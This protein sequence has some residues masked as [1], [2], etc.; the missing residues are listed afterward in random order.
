[1]SGHSLIEAFNNFVLGDP[2]VASLGREAVR[3]SPDFERAF[4]LGYCLIHG[5]KEWPLAFERWTTKTTVHPDPAKRSKYD[6]RRD[7]DPL[8]AVIAAEARVHRYRALVSLLRRGE[9][10]GRGLPAAAG[11]PETILRPVWSQEQFHFDPTTGDIL[12]DNA[13]SKD[14]YDRYI[15]RWLGVVLERR[16]T[17]TNPLG[18]ASVGSRTLRRRR[19]LHPLESDPKF[20]HEKPFTIAEV[21]ALGSLAEA[22]ARLVFRHPDVRVLCDRAIAVAEAQ[23]IPFEEDGGL[24]AEFSGHDERLLPLR[25]FPKEADDFEVYEPPS[26]EEDAIFA[27]YFHDGWPPDIKAYYDA[28][29]VRARALIEMLQEQRVLARGHAADGHLIPIA[30]TI[31]RHEDYYIHPPTGDVY[32]AAPHAMKKKWTGVILETADRP[33]E[34][35]MFHVKP[36]V[37]HVL[38]SATPEPQQPPRQASKAIARAET[39]SASYRACVAWL[40]AMMRTSPKVR[41]HNRDQLWEKAK[42]KWPLTLSSRAF[43]HAREEAI[44]QAGAHAWAAG[45]APKKSQRAK[46]PR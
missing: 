44:R 27:R 5:I 1:L 41:A 10:E 38:L 6:S 14:R 4:G 43:L 9:L 26:P 39:K 19:N 25:Y 20:S 46:L 16:A 29:N 32:E 8:E 3:L 13:E 36:I 45:G 40:V 30:H 7:P 42:E 21:L 12:Q 24:V 35:A 33:R 2:E 34:S 18:P 28:V 37:P 31:W 11:P 15:K 22:L 23:R 17:S